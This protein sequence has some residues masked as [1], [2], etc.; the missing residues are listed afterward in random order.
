LGHAGSEWK[1]HNQ[2]L[3]KKKRE[4]HVTDKK[5]ETNNGTSLL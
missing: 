4:P 5:K 1:A 3:A 2:N